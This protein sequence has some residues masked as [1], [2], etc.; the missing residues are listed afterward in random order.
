MFECFIVGAISLDRSELIW[1]WSISNEGR[2]TSGRG[3]KV[4][5]CEVETAGLTI[6]SSKN[7]MLN[8]NCK[9]ERVQMKNTN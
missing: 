9:F 7:H 5:I 6:E 3:A 4:L 8:D 1:N 2:G